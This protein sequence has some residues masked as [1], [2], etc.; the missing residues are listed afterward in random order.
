MNAEK[1]L[2]PLL[3]VDDEKD[4]CWSFKTMFDGKD[5]SVDTVTSGEEAVKSI[6]KKKYPVIILDS[7]LPNMDGF[8]VAK[9]IRKNFP[10]TKIIIFSGF[11]HRRDR[12]IQEGLQSGHFDDFISKPFDFDDVRELILSKL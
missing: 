11:Y 10:D 8:A 2:T 12:E 6:K 4:L 1:K 7:M 5:F 9:V 3:L